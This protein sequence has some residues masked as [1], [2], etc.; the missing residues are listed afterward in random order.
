MKSFKSFNKYFKK[1][2]NYVY[3]NAFLTV[4]NLMIYNRDDYTI[5]YNIEII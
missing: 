2:L 1:Y 5:R 3:N 4:W